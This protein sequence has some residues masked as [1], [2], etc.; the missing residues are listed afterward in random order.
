MKTEVIR[1]LAELKELT[2]YHY[3]VNGFGLEVQK[4]FSH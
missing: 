3:K 4:R 2:T 1:Q